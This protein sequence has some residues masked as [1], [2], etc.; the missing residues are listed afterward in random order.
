MLVQGSGSAMVLVLVDVRL[1]ELVELTNA[2]GKAR[3]VRRA[4]RYV[5]SAVRV[6]SKLVGAMMASC[7]LVRWS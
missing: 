2:S 5:S 6:W 3:E 1:G 7:V 4:V